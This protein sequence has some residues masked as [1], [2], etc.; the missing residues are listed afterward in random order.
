MVKSITTLA[1][2]KIDDA[3][4]VI[5]LVEL[6]SV[7]SLIFFPIFGWIYVQNHLQI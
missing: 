6:M 5:K 7:T 4:L 2:L 3:L 1:F